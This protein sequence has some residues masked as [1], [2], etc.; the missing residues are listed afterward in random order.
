VHNKRYR[1]RT[2]R[3]WSKGRRQRELAS[4]CTSPTYPSAL[5]IGV[6]TVM[7]ALGMRRTHEGATVVDIW[8]KPASGNV[9]M[10]TASRTAR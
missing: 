2:R 10:R 7:E 8:A 9:V 4:G 6:V 5:N 3:V 1:I